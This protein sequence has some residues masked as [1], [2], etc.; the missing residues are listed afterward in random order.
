MPLANI[1]EDSRDEYFADGMTEELIFTLSKIAKLRVIAR[2]SVMQFKG[3]PASVAEIGRLLD[4]GTVLEGSVRKAGNKIRIAVELVDTQSEEHLWSQQYERKLEDVFAIQSEIAKRV[5]S[6]LKVRIRQAERIEIEKQATGDLDAY[7][8]YLNGRY[9]WNQRT[10]AGLQQAITHFNNAL[11]RDPA[12]A[13]A[14]TGLADS[15]AMLALFEFVPP[16]LAFPK[17]KAAAEAALRIDANLAEAHTSL[18][19]VK[20]QYDRDWPG[21]ESEFKQ[22]LELNPNYPPAHQFYADYLKAMG[23]FS[24]AIAEMERALELDPVSLAINTGLGHALYLSRQ[25]DRAVAQYRKAVELDPAFPQAHLWFGRPYLQ[26]GMFA[27]AIAEVSEAVRLSGES[28]M[29]LGVLGHVFASAGQESEAEAILH[30]LSERAAKQYVPSYWIALIYVGLGDKDRAFEWLERAY[31][32]RSSWLAWVMVEPRFDGIR[33]DP[34]FASLLKRMRLEPAPSSTHEE[35]QKRLTDLLAGSTRLFL[36][37]YR[38]VGH[39]ARYEET[40]RNALKDFRQKIVAGLSSASPKHEN[41]LLWAPPGSGKTYFVQQVG[42]S[43]D[44]L[45]DFAAL[46]LAELS[47][48]EFRSALTELAHRSRPAICLVDE[49][50]SKAGEPWPYEALLT[51]LDAKP[52]AA[53]RKVFILAGSSG[54]DL[55]EFKRNPASRPKGSDMLSRVPHENEYAVPPL[56]TEDRVLVGL[57]TLQS[58]SMELDRKISDVEKLALYYIAVDPRLSS[59]RQLREFV[60]RCI[61]RV[62]PSDDRLRYDHLF[63]PGDTRNKEFWI[64]AK[65]ESPVLINSFVH[66]E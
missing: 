40:T 27:E 1:S 6:A 61:E 31:Q 54:S 8:E 29:A 60:F 62:P 13:L 30:R 26:K 55:D 35:H 12:F 51:H 17:A 9:F 34:R 47:E 3:R 25:Y 50:D 39:Y 37:G 7:G 53:G 43:V 16:S 33:S 41:Y 59:A 32:E 22:S 58:A 10:E 56:T 5:A 21:A 23:R 38:V 57:A 15:H 24:E 18:G 48:A 11:A 36:P 2:T 64:S 65:E 66:V 42:A 63:D 46:N 4:V 44:S 14:Y 49:V 20:F 19:L 28:T 52:S 45:A